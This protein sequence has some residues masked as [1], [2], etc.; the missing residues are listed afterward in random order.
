[1]QSDIAGL[2]ESSKRVLRSCAKPAGAI[3]A[4]CTPRAQAKNYRFVW[5]RDGAYACMAADILGLKIQEGFFGWCMRAQGWRRTGLFYEKY[6]AS[7]RKAAR[8]F[9]PDQTG[10]V[11]IALYGHFKGRPGRYSALAE[12]SADSLCRIWK[13][14]HF[15]LVCQD[16]WEERYSF[17]DQG[18]NFSYSLAVCA[19]GLECAH[20]MLGKAKWLA[21]ARQMK[22]ALHS[23]KSFGRSFGRFGDKR[24]DASLLGLAWPSL[25]VAPT[26]PRMK[27]AVREIEV[28]LGRGMRLHR[29]EGDDYD[30]WMYGRLH[31]KKGAGYWPL[32]NFWM[33]VYW[34]MAGQRRKALAYYTRVLDDLAGRTEIPEQI[35]RNQ[36][37][38]SVS[39]LCWSHAMFVIATERLGLL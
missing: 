28:R 29:Y 32:L 35:F 12:K 16:I 30:G 2:L 33:S 10:L 36:V 9:Q 24:I 25:T 26:D 14:D 38:V 4:A 13:S 15:G 6:Y 23:L 39:P 11:L 34:C 7:G 18:E 37:Q 22:R 21:T 3:L 1:M 31:R 8:G 27:M 17:P 20:A 5:P 19:R